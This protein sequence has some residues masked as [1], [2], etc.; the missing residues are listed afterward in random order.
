MADGSQVVVERTVSVSRDV[1][2]PYLTTGSLWSRWQGESVVIEAV[3]GGAFTVRMPD[4]PVASGTVI[5]V[6]PP[7]RLVITWGWIGTPFD[8]APGSTTVTFELTA[9]DTGG[10]RITVTH[11]GLPEELAGHHRDGWSTCLERLDVATS[12]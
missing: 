6:V 11:D 5:E 8:L 12:G 3:A 4:G 9:L 2:W 1:V 7:T 10:T